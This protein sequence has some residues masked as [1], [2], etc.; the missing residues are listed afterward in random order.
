VSATKTVAVPVERLYAA[1]T[2]EAIR[3]RWLPGDVEL[4]LRGA[5]AP[6]VARYDWGDGPSRVEAGFIALGPAKS[7]VAVEHSRLPDAAATVRQKAW[8]RERLA[9]LKNLLE[10]APG[11]ER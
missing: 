5:A 10:S 6:K 1:F 7:R 4:R 3:E 11:M 9:A 2:D 8:W